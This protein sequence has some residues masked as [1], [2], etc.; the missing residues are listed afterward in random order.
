VP[1]VVLS[2]FIL[3]GNPLIVMILMGQM[4]YTKKTGFM[5]GLTVAQISEFSLIM[6][7]VGVK[8]GH[9]PI[10]ALS[11]MTAIGLITIAGSTYMI[12]YS[13]QLYRRMS[14][15]LGFFEF[16]HKHFVPDSDA[17][18]HY[19]ILLFGYNRT[20]YDVLKSLQHLKGSL[21]VIDFSPDIIASLAREGVQCKYGDAS[22]TELLDELNVCKASLVISTI[23]DFD[24]NLLLLSK[25]REKNK[26]SIVIIVS[27]Q[28]E[29]ALILYNRG[30]TYVIIPHFLGGYHTA[31]LIED[32]GLDIK[33]FLTEQA[34]HIKYLEE[35]KY[36][37][38]GPISPSPK[39]Q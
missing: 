36:K 16:H 18:A 7:A 24:T 15:Y 27:H 14:K 3:I 11:F 34:K 17:T 38:E 39:K 5:A 37:G 8:M 1:I 33:K 10:S 9:L 2:V 21:L 29:E 28:A 31:A 6:I 25:I 23:P 20:G 19:D 4:G 32:F 26:H 35:H 22:D 13:E 30:A 12:L